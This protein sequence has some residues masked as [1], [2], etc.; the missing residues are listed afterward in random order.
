MYCSQCNHE[1][2]PDDGFCPKCGFRAG[3]GS[4]PMPAQSRKKASPLFTLLIVGVVCLIG[5]CLLGALVSI[6]RG[7]SG[8]SQPSPAPS[9][10]GVVDPNHPKAHLF[11]DDERKYFSVAGGYLKTVNEQDTRLATVMVGVRSGES[12]LGDIKGAIKDAR[13]IEN[14]GYSGDYQSASP[15]DVF[16][17]IDQKIQRCKKLHDSAFDELLDYWNDSNPAHIQSG[18]ATLKRAAVVTN[19]CIH[20]LTARIDTLERQRISPVPARAQLANTTE[21]PT[22]FMDFKWGA[23]PSGKLKKTTTNPDGTT[24]Y[25]PAAG[26]KLAPLFGLVVAEEA[27]VFSNNKFYSGSAWLDGNDNFDKMKSILTKKF[28]KPSFVNESMY[29]WKWGWPERKVEIDL[30]YQPKFARTTVTFNNNGI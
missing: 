17:D 9:A 11:S 18:S 25:V 26:N 28:G 30:S 10:G 20:D 16:S 1:L 4:P 24:M 15:P 2:G 21:P 12:T 23:P 8:G 3:S 22:G 19:E 27:Y 6:F 13:S 14:A 5:L 29:L 7:S